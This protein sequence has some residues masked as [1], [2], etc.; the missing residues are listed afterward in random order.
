VTAYF[1]EH[2]KPFDKLYV[3]AVE[4]TL[5]RIFGNFAYDAIISVM[6]ELKSMLPKELLRSP[7][8]L[9]E[10]LVMLFGRDGAAVITCSIVN[11]LCKLLNVTI[12]P[13]ERFP[14]TV[15]RARLKYEYGLSE[16]KVMYISP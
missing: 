12:L 15:R 16:D 2:L 6:C 8:A 14:E 9:E 1:K 7:E 5:R 13:S 10:A 11:Q 4:S 3:E